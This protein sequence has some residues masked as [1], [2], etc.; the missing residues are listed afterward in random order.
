VAVDHPDSPGTVQF[1][2]P[3]LAAA[4]RLA[5]RLR[6]ERTVYIH[7]QKELTVV[8]AELS[9]ETEDLALLLR[10]VET[11][12]AEEAL[13]AIRFELDGRAYILEAGEANWGL[14]A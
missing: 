12:V 14:A 5:R 3:D 9:A 1:E 10:T 7:G 6:A 2:I 8:W 11:W 4:A 13:R